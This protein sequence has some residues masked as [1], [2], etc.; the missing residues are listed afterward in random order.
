[1]V[2]TRSGAGVEPLTLPSALEAA[3]RAGVVC[4]VC[5]ERRSIYATA[6]TPCGH[7]ICAHCIPNILIEDLRNTRMPSCPICRRPADRRDNEDFYSVLFRRAFRD[8]AIVLLTRLSD[9]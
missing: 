9:Q 1:M 6:I 7:G 8:R 5:Y 2:H 4:P 3:A